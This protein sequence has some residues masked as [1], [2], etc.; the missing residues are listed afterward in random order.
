MFGRVVV[1]IFL[2]INC[3]NVVE[4]ASCIH[5]LMKQDDIGPQFLN[6]L[7]LFPKYLEQKKMNVASDLLMR[8]GLKT[9]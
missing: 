4:F 5:W 6:V 7:K 9:A 1:D 8:Y 2:R 3:K